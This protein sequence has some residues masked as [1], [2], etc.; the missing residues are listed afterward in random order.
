MGRKRQLQQGEVSILSL[1]DGGFTE[2]SDFPQIAE[3]NG[4]VS[5]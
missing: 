2:L 5:V 3:L 4:K 1:G